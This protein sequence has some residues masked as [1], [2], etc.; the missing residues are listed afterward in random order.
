MEVPIAWNA[1]EGEVKT[2]AYRMSIS[3]RPPYHPLIEKVGDES[4]KNSFACKAL[5]V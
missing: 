3:T 1:L 5:F 4:A 2:I